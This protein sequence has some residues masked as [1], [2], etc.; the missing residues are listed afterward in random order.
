MIR[1]R[2]SLLSDKI[3]SL[4]LCTLLLG[5]LCAAD[6]VKGAAGSARNQQAM[7]CAL[8]QAEEFYYNGEFDQ[9]IT[10]IEDCLSKD[11]PDQSVRIRA[12][13]LLA[14]IHLVRGNLTAAE[15]KINF[16]LNLDPSF[17]PSIEEETP[18]FVNLVAEVREK[19]AEKEAASGRIQADSTGISPW[20]WIGTGGAVLAILAII[21]S[22]NG[23][24]SIPPVKDRTLPAP[25]AF[26]NN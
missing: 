1:S 5:Y 21:S 20:I 8:D 9:A 11:S 15:E 22:D 7:A 23:G 12:Y 19:T 17:A 18:K 24:K 16:I 10:I 26:P 13:T 3:L 25:P 2:Y 4:L 14:R 6:L